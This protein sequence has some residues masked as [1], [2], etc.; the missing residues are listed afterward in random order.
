M[1]FECIWK[2]CISELLTSSKDYSMV[3]RQAP[4]QYWFL[5]GSWLVLTLITHVTHLLSGGKLLVKNLQKAVFSTER[6]LTWP[7]ILNTYGKCAFQ[8]FWHMQQK[9]FH[10]Y[11]TNTKSILAATWFLIVSYINNTWVFGYLTII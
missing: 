1:Y 10:G 11:Q 8:R 6:N 7:Y 9:L 2:M 3:T 5:H 4:N